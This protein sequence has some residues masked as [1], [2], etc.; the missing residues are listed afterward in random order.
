V[1]TREVPRTQR[2]A[3]QSFE[4]FLNEHSGDRNLAL[5]A[6]YRQG[7]LTMTH[8]ASQTGLSVSRVS[9]LIAAAEISDQ[10]GEAKGKT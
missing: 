9:R 3:T 2:R 5:A 4:W 10:L 8:L 7:G 6:A 1:Q